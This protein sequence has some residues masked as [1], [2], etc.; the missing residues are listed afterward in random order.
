MDRRR[1]L[2]TGIQFIGLGWYI[3]AAILV[4]CLAGL[5]LDNQIGTAPLFLLVGLILGLVVALYGTY[6][7]MI[8]FLANQ[9]DSDK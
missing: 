5:W 8:L 1:S 2:L 3:A 9:D 7:M 4:G 6:K